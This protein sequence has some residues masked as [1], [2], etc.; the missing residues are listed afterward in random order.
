MLA[1]GVIKQAI[2]YLQPAIHF[3]IIGL[4]FSISCIMEFCSGHNAIKGC[5]AG[6]GDNPVNGYSTLTA[7]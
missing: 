4:G 6:D 3:P 1:L 2:I 7:G 5:I